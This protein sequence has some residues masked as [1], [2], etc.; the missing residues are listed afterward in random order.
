[1]SVDQAL[2]DHPAK[3]G[4]S[5]VQVEGV[6]ND[7]PASEQLVDH[8]GHEVGVAIVQD[9]GMQNDPPAVVEHHLHADAVGVTPAQACAGAGHLV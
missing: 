2:E 8:P 3:M 6:Q 5:I 7:P 4:V 1:M 9:G